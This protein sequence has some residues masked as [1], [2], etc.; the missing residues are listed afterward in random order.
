MSSWSTSSD[1][2]VFRRWEQPVRETGNVTRIV[3][4]TASLLTVT[5]RHVGGRG[6]PQGD[7]T[8]WERTQPF[9]CT[10]RCE[11]RFRLQKYRNGGQLSSK[12]FQ[13]YYTCSDRLL[14]IALPSCPFH[15]ISPLTVT[16]P[17]LSYFAST[18]RILWMQIAHGLQGHRA[19]EQEPC[20]SSHVTAWE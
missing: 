10:I 16:F 5:S 11:N 15:L 4:A 3:D 1:A 20:R 18:I 12:C 19:E 7:S 17:K 8:W 6:R 2:N 13:L 14:T 9:P